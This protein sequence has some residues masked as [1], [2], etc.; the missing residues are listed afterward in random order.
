MFREGGD[1]RE[2]YLGGVAAF[3]TRIVNRLLE[4]A[5]DGGHFS[6]VA[7]TNLTGRHKPNIGGAAEH[8]GKFITSFAWLCPRSGVRR[9]HNVGVFTTVQRGAGLPGARVAKRSGQPLSSATNHEDAAEDNVI[10]S[11]L[12]KS[13]NNGTRDHN[14]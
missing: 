9:G 10:K 4:P 13:L 1:R 12:K 11:R 3:I 6:F 5:T 2:R 14:L 8:Y 7:V